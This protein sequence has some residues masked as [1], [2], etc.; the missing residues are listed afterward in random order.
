MAL[1][2]A[3][4]NETNDAKPTGLQDALRLDGAT[5]TAGFVSMRAET[6]AEAGVLRL[7]RR[8][9]AEALDALLHA[10]FWMDAAYVAERVLSV[11]ELKN[12]VDQNWS[13]PSTE[14]NS[15]ATDREFRVNEGEAIR[16]L[17]GRRLA[18]SG[19]WQ[20]A[21]AYYPH[22]LLTNYDALVG[23]LGAAM[24]P[25]TPKD[26]R[27]E[28]LL[29]ASGITRLHGLELL[30]Y[31]VEPDW[32]ISPDYGGNFDLTVIRR[33]EANALLVRA[34]ND[35][36]ERASRGL[37]ARRF[38]YR[39]EAA[40]LAMEAAKLMPD[41]T[42]EKAIVLCMAG[43]WLKARDPEAA[44]VYYKTLVR[45]CRKTAIGALA[46]R[47]RWFPELDQ[48]GNPAPW[49]APPPVETNA[50]AD[51]RADGF[52]YSLN[53]G[54]TLRDVAELVERR[55]QRTITVA[56]LQQANPNI[57]VNRLKAGC[58]QY[59]CRRNCR[60]NLLDRERDALGV[61]VEFRW[62]GFHVSAP[63]CCWI[64]NA[65]GTWCAARFKVSNLKA[66]NASGLP[67]TAAKCFRHA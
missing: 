16:Y 19:E 33:D 47:M 13:S 29:T 34:S 2:P 17:L 43:S 22:E 41:N 25:E 46:D 56:E 10:G 40:A 42:D 20:A 64:S 48:A 6:L 36:L 24:N 31:E 58:M 37:D 9:Y 39:Y 21:H 62:P 11:E 3:T 63:S 14:T 28:A 32:A 55:H 38:H 65:V 12:Y 27:I 1:F 50:P 8:E 61:A 4:D 53:R 60:P 30:G 67:R 57:N 54:N 51:M 35:E 59:L 52:W 44:D 66:L 18:R 45:H 26:D 7:T 23:A 49:E 5:Y 15:S